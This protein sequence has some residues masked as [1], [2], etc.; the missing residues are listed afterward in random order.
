MTL[1]IIYSGHPEQPSRIEKIKTRFVE[2]NLLNRM[3]HLQSR[4][5]TEE[6]ILLIHAPAHLENMKELKNC[7]NLFDAGQKFNSVYFHEKT[8]DCA[9]FAV[10]R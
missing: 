4:E 3:K 5:A 8:Y 9:K 7:G 10:G 1:I 6:E 2:Y